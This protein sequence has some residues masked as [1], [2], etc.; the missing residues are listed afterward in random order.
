VTTVSV[1]DKLVLSADSAGNIMNAEGEKV[2]IT[3][4]GDHEVPKG[5]PR[6]YLHDDG[7]IHGTN[8]HLLGRFS[9]EELRGNRQDLVATANGQLRAEACA[10]LIGLT[11]MKA[12]L[13][14]DEWFDAPRNPLAV[15]KKL[16][17][18]VCIHDDGPP[19]QPVNWVLV[20]VLTG[21]ALVALLIAA[22]FVLVTIPLWGGIVATGLLA[23]SRFATKARGISDSPDA[24]WAGL[25]QRLA[26]KRISVLVGLTYGVLVSVIYVVADRQATGN[27]WLCP[28][29]IA[30][31]LGVLWR[32]VDRYGAFA[33]RRQTGADPATNQTNDA[34]V[35]AIQ[36]YSVLVALAATTLYIGCSLWVLKVGPKPVGSTAASSP[37]AMESAQA[38]R[39]PAASEPTGDPSFELEGAG[40]D[41][42]QPQSP[43]NPDPNAAWQMIPRDGR[44]TEEAANA[45]LQAWVT[46]QNAGNA[47]SYASLYSK[48]FVGVKRTKSGRKTEYSREAWLK[49]RLKMLRSTQ[50]LKIEYKHVVVQLNGQSA[51]LRFDQYYRSKT[52]SDWGPKMI[53]LGVEDGHACIVREEL[54]AS[55]PL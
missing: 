17:Y 27:V 15:E 50:S 41:T 16:L 43:T 46:S 29:A 19:S 52:Y 14:Q 8:R 34:I 35:G 38:A 42:S 39:Q 47:A 12:K 51:I 33:C 13:P 26:A 45:I 44:I 18:V 30:I 10:A 28:I 4:Y 20:L 23:A 5:C 25:R 11:A 53:E 6:C 54:L 36:K 22:L 49:D 7:R 1:G 32:F 9:G 37:V 48:E 24:V 21:F 40:P 31:G 55:H 3:V 2:A